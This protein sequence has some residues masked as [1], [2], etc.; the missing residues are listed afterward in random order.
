MGINAE[1]K[2]GLGNGYAAEVAYTHAIKTYI[3]TPP[4]SPVGTKNRKR[5]FKETTT[6]LLVNGSV[7]PFE[8]AINP[9]NDYDIYITRIVWVVSDGTQNLS[10]FGALTALTNGCDLVVRELGTDTYLIDKAKTGGDLIVG[11]GMFSVFGSGTSVNV[12]TS[13]ASASDALIAIFDIA[14]IMGEGI[15]IGRGSKDKIFIKIND[16]LTALDD[17]F[18]EFFGYKLYE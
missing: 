12:V 5:F 10:K 8:Y 13:W 14:S 11:S 2:D 1:I 9:S 3:D 18:V 4:L 6:P 15:R 16:N 7:T 17:H